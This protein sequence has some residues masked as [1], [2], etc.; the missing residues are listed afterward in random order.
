[1]VGQTGKVWHVASL[2]SVCL[3][4]FKRMLQVL[5]AN[6]AKVDLDVAML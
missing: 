4:H 2:W 6:V 5:N 1:M 3:R